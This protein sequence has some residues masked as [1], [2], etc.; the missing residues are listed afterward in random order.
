MG[1]LAH[2]DLELDRATLCRLHPSVGNML[3]GFGAVRRAIWSTRLS[4]LCLTY[5]STDPI[6]ELQHSWIY[7]DPHSRL[8]EASVHATTRRRAPAR[9]PAVD[10][11]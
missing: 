8:W 7:T 5:R 1:V 10:V 4:T 2:A 11:R 6:V 3:F 9:R